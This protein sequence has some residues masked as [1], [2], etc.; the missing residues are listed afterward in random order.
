MTSE[1]LCQR[2]LAAVVA[3]EPVDLA[4]GWEQSKMHANR[5]ESQYQH[6]ARGSIFSWR[7]GWFTERLWVV[8]LCAKSSR[9][10]HLR[11]SAHSLRWGETSGRSRELEHADYRSKYRQ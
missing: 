3:I 2:K 7:C 9:Y 8:R 11:P 4:D 1:K 5:R 10:R 6:T